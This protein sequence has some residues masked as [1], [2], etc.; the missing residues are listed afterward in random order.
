MIQGISSTDPIF[1]ATRAG[2]G[3]ELDKDAFMKLLV[4]QMRNQDPLAPTDNQAFVAQLAQFSSLEE[5]QGVNENLVALAF[6]QESN[7]V[8]A[9]L[10][11]SSSLIGKH[12]SYADP[13]GGQSAQGV[14][15]SVKLI[16][17]VVL[18]HIDGQDVPLSHVT[19]VAAQSDDG[20]DS[21]S[22]SDSDDE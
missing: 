17:G 4:A 18:L 1:G 12:V 15:D 13:M 22:D 11:N 6:L 8:L 10:T 9:Q 19:E 5:M 7:A 14:V 21:D 20:G 2:G 16:E 3:Q